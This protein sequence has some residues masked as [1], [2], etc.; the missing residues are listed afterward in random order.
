MNIL[1][2]NAGSSS[3]KCCL[4]VVSG[5]LPGEPP[6][7]TW[8]AHLEQMGSKQMQLHV[9][10]SAGRHTEQT[11]TGK[12]EWSLAVAHTIRTLWSGPT[13]VLTRS[14]EIDIVGHRVVHGGAQYENGTLITPAVK[15][16]IAQL[17]LYAPLHNPAALESIHSIEASLPQ[18]PQLAVFDTAF[19]RHLS[20]A[21]S[22][23]PGPYEWIAQGIRRYGFHG[24]SHQYCSQRAESLLGRPLAS[25]KLVTCHLGNGCSL[26]AIS[27]GQSVDTT[28]GFTPLEGL[29]MGS[30]SGSIDPGILLHLLRHQGYTIEHLDTVLNQGSGLRGISGLSHDM[31]D[32]LA[33]A[34]AGNPRA[35]L[36]RDMYVYRL[37]TAIGA[38]LAALSGMDALVFTGGVGEHAAP[39]RA[40]VCQ[41]F[42]FL[43]LQLDEAKNSVAGSTDDQDIATPTSH[44]RV[45]VVH[46]Q[47]NWVIAQECWR[48]KMGQHSSQEDLKCPG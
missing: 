40:A 45:L 33:A 25:L 24:L 1:V 29:M 43:G 4:Y 34:E 13:Q 10:T 2:L 47:E 28:M 12:I 3:L 42:G 46:A 44:I 37:R 23:Y 18:T 17:A 9:V 22:Y 11:F 30:R 5:N 14:A 41:A 27:H 7:A 48:W 8:A 26:A 35:V 21:V 36:A 6:A 39:I 38:M 15:E 19:H 20:P 32:V 16:A 31:R